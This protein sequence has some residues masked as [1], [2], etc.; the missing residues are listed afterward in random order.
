MPNADFD[1]LVAQAQTNESA[2]D[3]AVTLLNSLS[4]ILLN[5]PSPAQIQ[6]L[7]QD[8]KTHADALAAAI[9]ANTPAAPTA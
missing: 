8:L 3:S 6:Q 5:N 9:V 4:A 7:G 1:A 2:E